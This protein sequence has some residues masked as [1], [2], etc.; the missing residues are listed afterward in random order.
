LKLQD[1]LR[2]R[3][4]APLG[5]NEYDW[6]CS[7]QD[8]NIGGWGLSI[9]TE[10]IARFGQLYL[11]KG[12]WGGLQLVPSNW[13]ET[14]TL[15][16]V[17]NGSNPESDWEQG[18]GYHFWRCRHGAYRGDGAFGQFCVVM[19]KQDAVLAITGGMDDMQP[20]LNLVWEYL[21]PGFD[22]TSLPEDH[23]TQSHLSTRLTNLKLPMPEGSRSSGITEE[24]SGNIYTFE[25]NDQKFRSVCFDFSEE[26]CFAQFQDERGDHIVQCG[27]VKWLQGNTTLI[28]RQLNLVG[29]VTWQSEDTLV[30]TL[31]FYETPFCYTLTCCFTDLSITIHV[32]A[33][34]WFGPKEFQLIG[35]R[36]YN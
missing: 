16:H 26:G 25:A 3:L 21:L 12:V 33:N 30:M 28:E 36:I 14:A 1:Y 24:I 23:Q 4:F 13:V 29:C 19:P 10:A 18:Y 5:I 35:T 34:V 8:I 6:E 15:G 31:R 27:Y 2:P 9:T 7:P 11:Q 20:V 22:P 32:A 17:S